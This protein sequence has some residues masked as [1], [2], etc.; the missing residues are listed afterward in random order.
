MDQHFLYRGT[1]FE[2][3]CTGDDRRGLVRYIL[4][5]LY[6]EEYVFQIICISG[7]YAGIINGYVKKETL[8]TEMKV[9]AITLKH[10]KNELNNNFENIDW[11]SFKLFPA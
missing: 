11:D 10:L 2:F 1:F 5:E 7:Y 4:A 8:V 3:S 9:A 6:E